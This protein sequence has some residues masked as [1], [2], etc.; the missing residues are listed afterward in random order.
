MTF[1]GALITEQNVTFAV[2][3]VKQR[4]LANR[5]EAQRAIQAF[6]PAF[7][8]VP[9]VLMAQDGRGVPSYY[10]RQDIVKFMAQVPLS[11]VPWRKFTLS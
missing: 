11:A 6:Q 2:V 7:L 10:G 4:V 3:I 1:E 8:G 5:A 9:V